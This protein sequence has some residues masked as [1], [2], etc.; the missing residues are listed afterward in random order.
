MRWKPEKE[1]F[2]K[3]AFYQLH[4]KEREQNR[5]KDKDKPCQ[6]RPPVEIGIQIRDSSC[7]RKFPGEDRMGVLN[8]LDH[9][10]RPP[11]PLFHHTGNCGGGK[12]GSK[13]F[14][15]GIRDIALFLHAKACF[16]IFC[17]GVIG[18]TSDPF[19]GLAQQDGIASCVGGRIGRFLTAFCSACVLLRHPSL[20]LI[21]IWEKK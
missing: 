11:D 19:Y 13:N 18:E 14:P 20:S 1:Q 9:T 12:S 21:H 3:A 2:P 6:E 8:T 4:M 17:D 16:K 5:G 10:L 15:C 7:K